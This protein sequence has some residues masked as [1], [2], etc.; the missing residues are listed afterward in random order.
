MGKSL[1]GKELGTG[2]SQ[3]KD[4]LYQA[5][6]TNRFGKRETI[7]DKSLNVIK[8]RLRD[9]EYE[10]DK[11]LNIISKD[12]TLNEWF[13]VWMDICKKHCR[14][15]TKRT[16]ITSY[17]RIRGKLGDK[18]LSALNLIVLQDAINHLSTDMSRKATKGVLVDMF[19][20]AID[21]DLLSKNIAKQLQTVITK[22]KKK[23]R[24]A[25]TKKETAIFLWEAQNTYYYNLYVLALETGMRIGELTALMWNNINFEKKF[26]SV[27]RTLCYYKNGDK[28]GFAL[29]E[30]KT[31]HGKR[32]IPLSDKAIEVLLSQKEKNDMMYI[33]IKS[34]ADEYSN[35]VFIARTGRPVHEKLVLGSIERILNKVNSKCA[36]ILQVTP[37]IFRHTFATRAIE[38]GMNPKT[39]QKLLGHA[40]L[41]MTMDLYCH[42]TDDTLFEEMQKLESI[43]S[44][45]DLVENG[46][47]VV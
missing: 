41:Q 17:N 24:N 28:Y 15:S 40:T 7:Y 14:N 37:H 5:R 22:D 3:R 11:K 4:G 32:I 1:K 16:Y 10:D 33:S 20:K 46:V 47:V 2:I 39:L 21:S 30:P 36:L 9:S 12:V 31:R 13:D 42:V 29:H 45:I 23:D 26:L 38:S 35:L 19:D 25:L 27:E 6:F 43:T 8:K 44:N 18:L 34:E